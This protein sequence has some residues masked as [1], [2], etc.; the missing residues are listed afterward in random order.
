MALLAVS[1]VYAYDESEGPTK[2]D[3]GDSDPSVV[4]RERDTAN[5]KKFSGWTNPL[6]WTDDGSDDDTVVTQLD[7]TLD[8]PRHHDWVNV[9]QGAWVNLKTLQKA[10]HDRKAKDAYDFDNNTVSPYD[11]MH[12]YRTFDWGV[13]AGQPG[14]YKPPPYG[15]NGLTQ[16]K[17]VNQKKAR[18]AYDFDENTVSQ[19][20]D[21]EQYRLRDWG[22][23]KGQPGEYKP[24]IYGMN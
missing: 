14:E 21:M 24:P 15:M 22:V 13:P 5:G 19:Y 11:D 3:N 18:D 12:Q 20:D 6:S 2:A 10:K 17:T 16:K 8:H 7:S 9:Q 4:G 1:A 23:P